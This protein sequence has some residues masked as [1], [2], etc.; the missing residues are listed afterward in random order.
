M[1][2]KEF[3]QSVREVFSTV[4]VAREEFET[5]NAIIKAKMF[6]E[7]YDSVDA[8]VNDKEGHLWRALLCS[9]DELEASCLQAGDQL[10]YLSFAKIEEE[11]NKE[12]ENE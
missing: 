11:S 8:F 3:R 2:F 10:A 9:I 1:T 7:G 5:L 6:D 4:R 12:N